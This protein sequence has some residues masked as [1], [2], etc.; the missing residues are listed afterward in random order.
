M[1]QQPRDP[2]PVHGWFFRPEPSA[3]QT[4]SAPCAGVPC[5]RSTLGRRAWSEARSNQPYAQE[6]G[7]SLSEPTYGPH[8]LVCVRVRG[9]FQQNIYIY[10]ISTGYLNTI[11]TN[12]RYPNRGP[13][14][15]HYKSIIPVGQCTPYHPCRDP[16][17]AR[18]FT[19]AEQVNSSET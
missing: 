10:I 7:L 8:V 9:A 16:G 14:L 13:Y 15:N 2:G 3:R 1:A 6:A 5:S 11:N 19:V 18:R 4:S 12:G 17:P